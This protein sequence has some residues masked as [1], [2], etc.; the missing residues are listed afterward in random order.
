MFAMTQSA[1]S[2]LG[3]RN[4]KLDMTW[5]KLFGQKLGVRMQIDDEPRGHQGLHRDH[6]RPWRRPRSRSSGGTRRCAPARCCA[7]IPGPGAGF[8]LAGI[9]PALTRLL[10]VRRSTGAP[11]RHSRPR[12]RRTSSSNMTRGAR[13]RIPAGK[14]AA[15][16]GACALIC[17]DCPCL[18]AGLLAVAPARAQ[19]GFDRPGG[20]YSS[21]PVRSADPAACAARCEREGRCRAWSFSY[22]R[23]VAPGAM[24][25]LKNQV[26]HARG[27]FLL[28]LGREGRGRAGAQERADRVLDRPHR[29]RLSQP[30]R[31][32]PIR[33]ARPARRPAR[34]KSAAAPGPMCGRAISAPRRAAS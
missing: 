3:L 20:D 32:R 2:A 4:Q 24:C 11:E 28:R 8:P 23:T 14:E 1:T 16:C 13:G 31:A 26:T 15:E 7:C 10:P 17:A 33:P 6:P 25:W 30:G 27:G 9:D 5:S 21:F 18:V 22:P 34:P 12:M 19:T 29:R